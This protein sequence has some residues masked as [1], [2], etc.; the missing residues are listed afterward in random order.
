M[1]DGRRKDEWRRTARIAQVI[2]NANRDAKA[3]PQPF[4]DDD[5]NDYAPDR[6][7]EKP[8]RMPITILKTLFV[9]D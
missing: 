1:V 3:H 6:V 8:L 9:K 5:F 4:R 7:P 2:A